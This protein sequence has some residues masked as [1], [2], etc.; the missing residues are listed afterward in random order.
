MTLSHA[1]IH[2][3]Q[4]HTQRNP[5]YQRSRNVSQRNIYEEIPHDKY[6]GE[7]NKLGEFNGVGTI[8]TYYYKYSGNWC[9]NKRHG[10]GIL[11]YHNGDIYNCTW[12]NNNIH[13]IGEIKKNGKTY[14]GFF[15]LKPNDNTIYKLRRSRRIAKFQPEY[16][17]II[18]KPK[19]KQKKIQKNDEIYYDFQPSI[20]TYIT[21]FTLFMLFS[22]L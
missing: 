12:K 14:F 16:K 1:N 6:Y 5:S 9:K 7:I 2:M 19:K 13:G 17:G 21:L 10:T 4:I 8:Y 3:I 22:Y 18:Y 15:Y 20:L 11:Q